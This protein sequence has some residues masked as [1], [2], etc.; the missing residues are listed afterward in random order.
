MSIHSRLWAMEE[1]ISKRLLGLENEM[2]AMKL[3]DGAKH[4]LPLTPPDDEQA[5][6]A[7]KARLHDINGTSEALQAQIGKPI[8]SFST[9]EKT[10][11]WMP[12]AVRVMPPLKDVPLSQQPLDLAD[13]KG[14]SES[15]LVGYLGG[16]EFAPSVYYPADGAKLK[17]IGAMVN[18]KT[19]C[20]VDSAVEPFA[21]TSPGE[22]GAKLAVVM[23]PLNSDKMAFDV[24]LFVNL[25]DGEERKEK[26]M[27]LGHYSQTRW[28]DRLDY[29]RAKEIVPIEVK[30][31]WASLLADK[32]KPEWMKE[33]LMTAIWPK[34]DYEG[35]V[36]GI[37]TSG[38]SEGPDE[39]VED[40]LTKAEMDMKEYLNDLAD[41]KTEAEEKVDNL[42]E[43]GVL[44]ALDHVR[45]DGCYNEYLLTNTG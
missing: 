40:T 42:T 35:V 30:K 17:K 18:H 19:Y 41:W 1:I 12:S 26:Y 4:S 33:V 6:E 5:V 43:E 11:N 24:P 31:H 7:V 45:K 22:H 37:E 32:K 29:D 15:F 25:G 38:P 36:P 13:M 3:K 2:K 8:W 16:T 10:K 44:K 28:S 23:R 34:P 20:I 39:K 14:F 21:P 27:Y 9:A